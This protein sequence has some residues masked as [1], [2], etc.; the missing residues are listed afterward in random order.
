MAKLYKLSNKKKDEVASAGRAEAEAQDGGAEEE[1]PEEEEEALRPRS[2][3]AK[4]PKQPKRPRGDDAPADAAPRKKKASAA[5]GGEARRL[6]VR[7]QK[8]GRR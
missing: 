4:P 3:H 5:D 1:E 7:P 8:A 6:A 2:K